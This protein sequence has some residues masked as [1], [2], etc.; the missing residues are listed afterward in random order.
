MKSDAEFDEMLDR[1]SANSTQL[2]ESAEELRAS[3]KE[4]KSELSILKKQNEESSMNLKANQE[5]SDII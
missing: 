3:I 1:R 2:N 5:Y 4:L